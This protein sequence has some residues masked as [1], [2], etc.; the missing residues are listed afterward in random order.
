MFTTLN[1]AFVA[2]VGDVSEMAHGKNNLLKEKIYSEEKL[3]IP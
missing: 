3:Q 1:S 2:K